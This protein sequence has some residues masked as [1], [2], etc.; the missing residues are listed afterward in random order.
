MLTKEQIDH[1]WQLLLNVIGDLEPYKEIHD[2]AQQAIEL[3]AENARLKAERTRLIENGSIL[4][5]ALERASD[6]LDAVVAE[7]KR[8][9]YRFADYILRIIDKD[10]E[11]DG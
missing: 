4:S 11:K 3:A 9:Q 5:D 2:Q 6:K 10:G 8:K 7:C 1:A